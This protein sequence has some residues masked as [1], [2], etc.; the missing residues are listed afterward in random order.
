MLVMLATWPYLWANPIANFIHVFRL[1]S[2]NPTN[3]PVLFNSEVY[4]A[5]ELPLRYLPFMLTT[6]LT[7]PVWILFTIGLSVGFWKRISKQIVTQG[8]FISLT[9]ILFWFIILIV[10]VLLSRP[11]M[12]DGF[13]HFLFILPPVFIFIG[14]AFEFLFD[15]INLATKLTNWLRAGLLIALL[16]PGFIGISQLH[17][18]EYSYYNSF[19]GGTSGVFRKYETEYWLTCYKE[20]VERLNQST[21]EPVNLFVKREAYI[22]AAYAYDNITVRDL[23]GA[24][25]QVQSGDYVLVNTRTNEDR[26]TF[27][28]APSMIEIK[29]RNATFCIIKGIP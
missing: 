26:S 1:M 9:L 23:R 3:L 2:D 5:G 18:F 7:E 20:A 13:R 21:S 14:V 16:A 10:Y 4:R 6:T 29:R 27:K 28:D 12:Y 11:A 22:A 17:P 24:M 25:D 8:Y 19:V 15:K